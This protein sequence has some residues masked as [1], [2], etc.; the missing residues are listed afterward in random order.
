MAFLWELGIGWGRLNCR[1]AGR[2]ARHMLRA[3]MGGVGGKQ[4]KTLP[5]IRMGKVIKGRQPGKEEGI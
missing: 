1:T 4:G 2:L 5:L 3:V